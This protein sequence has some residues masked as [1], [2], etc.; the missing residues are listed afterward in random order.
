M[1]RSCR[2]ICMVTLWP[3][4][5]RSA[6]WRFSID[7]IGVR[8]HALVLSRSRCTCGN[9]STTLAKKN[10]DN[11]AHVTQARV[12]SSMHAPMFG[13]RACLNFFGQGSRFHDHAKPPVSTSVIWALLLDY[14]NRQD[15]ARKSAYWAHHWRTTIA[16]LNY[17]RDRPDLVREWFL[18]EILCAP[19][20]K[21]WWKHGS[22]KKKN[23]KNKH[24]GRSTLLSA[25]MTFLLHPTLASLR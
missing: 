3:I 13:L 16:E 19:N 8:N 5:L 4:L 24:E 21:I 14:G 6:S 1:K 23:E 11:R 9:S 15:T 18:P 20:K 7:R 25:S 2:T 12:L 10:R 22:A 17:L